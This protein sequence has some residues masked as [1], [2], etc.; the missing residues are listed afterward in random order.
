M[1]FL[2]SDIYPI[3]AIFVIF[4][5]LSYLISLTSMVCPN[6]KKVFCLSNNKS[7]RKNC[8]NYKQLFKSISWSGSGRILSGRSKYNSDGSS[9]IQLIYYSLPLNHDFTEP[10]FSQTSTASDMV[11]KMNHI[12]TLSS[13]GKCPKLH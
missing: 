9:Y 13:I 5:Y 3:P 6:H 12:P 7:T 11:N 2:C 4:W 8:S 1:I 10:V